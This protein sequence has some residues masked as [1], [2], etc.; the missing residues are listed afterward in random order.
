[1]GKSRH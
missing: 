1:L